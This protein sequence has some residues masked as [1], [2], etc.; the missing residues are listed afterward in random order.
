MENYL[1]EPVPDK[2]I[3]SEIISSGTKCIR[4]PY[5]PD[6]IIF[7]FL[8]SKYTS[9]TDGFYLTFKGECPVKLD[10][11][12]SGRTVKIFE[13]QYNIGQNSF[14]SL[15]PISVDDIIPILTGMFSSIVLE[16][17]LMTEYER[18][19]ISQMENLGVTIEKNI[20]IPNYKNL[21]LF[22]S[23]TMSIDPFIPEITGNREEAMKALKEI[24]I[25]ATDRLE[26]LDEAKINTLMMRIASSVMKINPKFD[27]TDLVADRVYFMEYDTL[28]LA[29]TV[30]YFLD[31]KGIGDLFQL[32]FTPNYAE[33]LVM[34][35]R[36][37]MVKG[38]KI[39]GITENSQ[40]Y[41]VDSSLKSPILLQ[42]IYLQQ[43]RVRRDKPIFVKL[44]DGLYTSRYFLT[45]WAKEGLNKVE[46]KYYAKG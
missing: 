14:S 32:V 9:N 20:K 24:G 15:F 22:S 46:D 38:F 43:G 12:P 3:S 42:L 13:R 11:T 17:R 34:K 7:S 41:V 1:K 26:D 37:E 25:E 10:I 27:R 45:S 39:N 18:N 40:F 29:Y 28:E 31:L 21:P 30:L 23:L 4:I 44:Q 35:F 33:T 5:N 2:Q 36:D 8:I 6:S 16:R 19:V